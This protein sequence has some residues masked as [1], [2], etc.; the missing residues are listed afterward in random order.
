LIQLFSS[1]CSKGEYFV[2]GVDVERYDP[3]NPSKYLCGLLKDEIDANA[4]GAFENY[5]GV[6]SSPSVDFENFTY[7]VNKWMEREPFN[8]PNPLMYFGGVERVSV[9]L[10]ASSGTHLAGLFLE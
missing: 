9:T 1:C 2:L 4:I 8:F 10:T 5:V 7:L 3:D 6:V